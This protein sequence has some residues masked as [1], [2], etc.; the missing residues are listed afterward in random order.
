MR[1]IRVTLN[2]CAKKGLKISLY[3][4]DWAIGVTWSG[5]WKDYDLVQLHLVDAAAG[6]GGKN[7]PVERGKTL[8]EDGRVINMRV[9]QQQL[10]STCY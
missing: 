3:D 8:R 4:S 6:R 1:L 7:V 5:N 10:I 9:D 2:I